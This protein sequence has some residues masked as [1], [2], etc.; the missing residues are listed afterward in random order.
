VVGKRPTHARES[1][2]LLPDFVAESVF[3][4]LHLLIGLAIQTALVPF[5]PSSLVFPLGCSKSEWTGNRVE[6]VRVELN[7]ER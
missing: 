5:V 2:D 7:E 6:G 3:F 1:I 4:S